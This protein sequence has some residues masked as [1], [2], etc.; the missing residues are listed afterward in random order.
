MTT[1][2]IVLGLLGFAIVTAYRLRDGVLLFLGLLPTYLIRYNIGPLPTTFLEGIFFIL[3]FFWMIDLAKHP[4]KNKILRQMGT[5]LLFIIIPLFT[6]FLIVPQESL[7]SSLGLWRAYL[8]EPTLFL[9]IVRAT[10]IHQEDRRYGLFSL[11]LC[12]CVLTAFAVFQYI[13]GT[14]L[15]IAWLAERRSTSIFPYPNALG[16]FLSPLI[17]SGIALAIRNNIT[18]ERILLIL[19]SLWMFLGVVLAKTEAG[20][21]AIILSLAV[22]IWL[23]TK[24]QRHKQLILLSGFLLFS[25]SLLF[26]DIRAK[27]FL[28]DDSGMVRRSQWGETINLLRDAPILG[29]GIGNFPSALIPYHIAKEYELFQYPHTWILNFWVEYGLFG[30]LSLLCISAWLV[31]LI[32]L[33]K[34]LPESALWAP[35]ILTLLIHGLVDVPFLK[36]DLAFLTLF[37]LALAIQTSTTKKLA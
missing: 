6:S 37:F 7:L 18:R 35:A 9:F 36:N 12:G 10:L 27:I 8:L 11:M 21:L 3:T 28:C 17:A 13:S 26:G 24:K 33:T 25:G 16:L 23:S 22:W 29:A 34:D 14:S 2:L 4:Q 20:I 31:R 15:P 19:A 30:A 32:F 5:T 1:L